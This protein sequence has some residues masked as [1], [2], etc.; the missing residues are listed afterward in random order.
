MSEKTFINGQECD[1]NTGARAIF[2]K[3]PV[4]IVYTWSTKYFEVADI[5]ESGIL[6]QQIQNIREEIRNKKRGIK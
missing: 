2:R 4:T 5:Y 6:V 3:L 1:F